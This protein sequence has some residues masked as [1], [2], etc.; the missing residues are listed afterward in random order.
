KTSCLVKDHPV[1]FSVSYFQDMALIVLDHSQDL[2]CPDHISRHFVWIPQT[3]LGSRLVN[4][5]PYFQRIINPVILLSQVNSQMAEDI[6]DIPPGRMGLLPG[7]GSHTSPFN[8]DTGDPVSI[9][10]IIIT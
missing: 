2:S 10:R 1:V 7:P 6:P 3:V 8:K 4:N 5:V 9:S